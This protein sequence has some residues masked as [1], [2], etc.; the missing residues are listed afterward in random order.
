MD[1]F[2]NDLFGGG[3]G[4][5]KF[6]FDFGPGGPGGG[7]GGRKA[8]DEVIPYDVTLED[9]YNGKS[10]KMNMEKDVEC[11]TCKG[12]GARGSA[13]PKKC[14]SC[15]GKGWTFVQSSLG[16]GRIGTS[17]TQCHECDGRGEKLKEKDRCKKCKGERIVKE[18]VRQEIF[19]EK[20]MAEGQR[21]VLPGAG[22]QEPGVP[23]GD[24]IFLL[25]TQQHSSFERSGN[26]LLTTVQVTLSEALLGFDRIL[27]NHL[28]GRGIKVASPAGKVITSGQTL[29]L[30]GE[31]MPTHK[32]PD[33]RGNLY[34]VLEVEMPSEQ[35]LQTIDLNALQALLPPKRVDVDPQPE[36]VDTAGYEES[37]MVDVREQA[38]PASAEF[39]DR[40]FPPQFGDDE[41]AW[42]DEDDE[43]G[44]GDP[45]CRTQ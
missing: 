36:I 14:V 28:D 42:E 19:I 38:F 45:E 41:N 16:P 1:D 12:S 44:Q 29:V 24:V 25:K 10:V 33:V 5:A 15:E 23:P 4:G 32:N 18:K 37:D 39:F 22:D 3:G 7:F 40:A 26:D 31:G 35:W 2:F 9:L 6:G 20:G 30:R 34:V 11:G 21:I 13:K 8:R 43:D 27:V 17:R